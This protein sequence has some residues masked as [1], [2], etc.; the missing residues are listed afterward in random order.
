MLSKT[1]AFAGHLL[2]VSHYGL[3]GSL[4]AVGVVSASGVSI[5]NK[6][7]AIRESVRTK[8]T[9]CLDALSPLRQTTELPLTTLETAS[10]PILK[11]TL[12]GRS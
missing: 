11:E 12:D 9:Q 7:E 3:S 4:A 6:Q 1:L 2:S 10:S 5:E 8:E